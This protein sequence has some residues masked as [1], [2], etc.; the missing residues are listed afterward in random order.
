MN[1]TQRIWGSI[2]GVAVLAGGLAVAQEL[3]NHPNLA[4]AERACHQAEDA[5]HAAQRANHDH[6][7][8]HASRAEQLLQQAEGE[9]HEAAR[10]ANRH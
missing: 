5:L 10:A 9:I 6:L 3:R 8:G 7:G 1:R 4:A 2:I